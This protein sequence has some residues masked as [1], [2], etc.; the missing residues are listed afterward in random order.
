MLEHHAEIEIPTSKDN[1]RTRCSFYKT[2]GRLL[3]SVGSTT[4]FHAFIVPIQMKL[5]QI[6]QGM[7]G[8]PDSH[9]SNEMLLQL[10][11][12]LRGL[13]QAIIGR[14]SY[15]QFF[16]WIYH[17]TGL[18]EWMCKMIS[19]SSKQTSMGINERWAIIKFTRE[20]TAN[21][22]K[23]IGFPVNSADGIRLFRTSSELLIH[24][25]NYIMSSEHPNELDEKIKS[26]TLFLSC[27]HNLL[28]GGFTNFGVFDM[29]QDSILS[30]SLK[31]TWTIILQ[32]DLA[33]LE[34]YPKTSNLVFSVLSILASNHSSFLVSLD[35]GSFG[36]L[37]CI[38]LRGIQSSS[39][40]IVTKSCVA[41]EKL[42][43]L[44]VSNL[45]LAQQHRLSP[46]S[47]SPQQIEQM[48]NHI[49][50]HNNIT[51]AILLQLINLAIT[52]DGVSHLSKPL[53]AMI[54][55]LGKNFQDIQQV[56]IN[57]QS[58]QDKAKAGKVMLL[59]NQLMAD[60]KSN[61]SSDNTEKFLCNLTF[62]HAEIQPLLDLNELYKAISRY[63]K[64][65]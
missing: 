23:R 58:Q 46:R 59:F 13:T 26:S 8:T 40:E 53:L 24:F 31:I 27:V 55:L 36:K 47:A 19:S 39:K 60:V 7:I 49:L 37:L 18:Y 43:S 63:T 15:C 56:I 52:S 5:N 3:W 54:L 11:N 42:F 34:V 30:E 6:Q 62:L 29:Y 65:L 16:T 28:S 32:L 48:N 14:D 22:N 38:L 45:V 2:L 61:L 10:L 1:F 44:H 20:L 21:E 17:E 64:E 33:L 57:S 9:K 4:D 25:A 50:Y 35:T 12:D 51:N 41:I